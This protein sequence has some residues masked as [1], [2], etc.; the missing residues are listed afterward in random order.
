MCVRETIY[1]VKNSKQ[2]FI[3]IFIKD[4]WLTIKSASCP[5][6]KYD[7]S[8]DVPK[9]NIEERTMESNYSQQ[10]GI[11]E[12]TST[13]SRGSSTFSLSILRRY[14]DSDSTEN[15]YHSSHSG[16]HQNSNGYHHNNTI[17]AFGPTIPVD[18]AEAFSRTWMAKSL[19]RNMRRQIDLAVAAQQR[20]NTSI[21]LPVRMTIA[22]PESSLATSSYNRN[23]PFTIDMMQS[24]PISN[25]QQQQSYQSSQN[26][27]KL[28]KSLPRQWRKN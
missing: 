1:F 27:K 17:S 14:M 11:S 16:S 13:P 18:Q 5:L 21:E 23:N 19:P 8:L 22:Q 28:F 24:A 10:F 20:E 3:Y 7:C 4:P 9:S 25:Q 15:N 12:E 26:H 2:I 6:C